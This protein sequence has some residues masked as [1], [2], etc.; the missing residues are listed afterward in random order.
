MA[1]NSQGLTMHAWS[2]VAA[3][4]SPYINRGYDVPNPGVPGSKAQPATAGGQ[5]AQR[6]SELHADA[7]RAQLDWLDDGCSARGAR[8]CMEANARHA[9][10]LLHVGGGLA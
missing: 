8:F 4:P 2:I 3:D 9:A 6:A 7:V 5:S 10:G 1:G